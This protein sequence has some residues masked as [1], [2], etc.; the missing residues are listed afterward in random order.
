MSQSTLT[1]EF[2]PSYRR[3]DFLV[4]PA[5]EEAYHWITAWPEA[6]P[7]PVLNLY[8]SP[9]SGK[10]HLAHIW[11]E[12]SGAAWLEEAR[13]GE[14]PASA[15]LAGQSAWIVEEPHLAGRETPWFHLLNTVR[16][17]GKW[18]LI[19]SQNALSRQQVRLSDLASRVAA[20]PAIGLR[21]PDDSLLEAVFAKRFSDMQL[22]VSP[23]V[24]RFLLG[25]MERSFGEMEAIIKKLDRLS[26]MEKK[27]ITL[28]LARKILETQ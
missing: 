23:D 8:G 11:Q 7:S 18:L 4:S 1:F 21:D 20:L 16:E 12:Q 28:P 5:N 9:G 15:L 6:W 22:K 3:E 25:R 13:L 24:V 10:T 19:T 27:N 26:L 14:A 2:L 17:E